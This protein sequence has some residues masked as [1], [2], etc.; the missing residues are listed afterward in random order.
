MRALEGKVS[1][2]VD[3]NPNPEQ[4]RA[5]EGKVSARVDPNPNP[6]QVRALEGAGRRPQLRYDASDG[7]VHITLAG[8]APPQS[9]DAVELRR[10]CCSPSNR[11]DALPAEL[12]PLDLVPMGNYAVS[13]RWS[14]GHQSLLP[15]RSFVE[16]YGE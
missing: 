2:R 11:P 3:P 8:D 14:D 7:M 5:L 12:T 13:V 1:A 9:I 4:V 15:Y 10:R 6:E 16:G